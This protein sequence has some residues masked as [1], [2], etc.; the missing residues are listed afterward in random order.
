MVRFLKQL[1]LILAVLILGL[2]TGLTFWDVPLHAD[3][4]IQNQEADAQ[5]EGASDFMASAEARRMMELIRI[6]KGEPALVRFEN[7]ATKD[8]QRSPAISSSDT[9]FEAW[10]DE[11][12]MEKEVPHIPEPTSFG[13]VGMLLLFSFTARRGRRVAL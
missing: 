12:A 5:A 10:N 8:H 7:S 6:A 3:V 2:G 13:F 1:K 4:V 9:W 11:S